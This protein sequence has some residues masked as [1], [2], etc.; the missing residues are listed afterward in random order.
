MD[1]RE[2]A[3]GLS[4]ALLPGELAAFLWLPEDGSW[5]RVHPH[6]KLPHDYP[7]D[8]LFCLWANKSPLIA[9]AGLTTGFARYC[10]TPLGLEVRTILTENAG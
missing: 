2:I 3:A 6:D 9:G 10:L 8:G 4:R 1:A 7:S 5:S